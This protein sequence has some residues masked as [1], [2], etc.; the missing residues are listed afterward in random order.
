MKAFEHL[1]LTHLISHAAPIM[2]PFQFAHGSKLLVE[3]VINLALHQILHHLES[4]S[5][6]TRN[7]FIDFI[8]MFSTNLISSQ[9]QRPRTRMIGEK[10]MFF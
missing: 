10:Q 7:L 5:T 8:S 1:V 6:Y 4:Y 3:D 2:D 9:V